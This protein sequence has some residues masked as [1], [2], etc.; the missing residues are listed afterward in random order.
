MD[1]MGG[2]GRRHVGEAG[3]SGTKRITNGIIKKGSSG[4]GTAGRTDG[5]TNDGPTEGNGEGLRND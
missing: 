2:R 5:V 4:N 1:M 3:R